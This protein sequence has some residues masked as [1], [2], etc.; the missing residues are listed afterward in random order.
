VDLGV[1]LRRLAQSFTVALLDRLDADDAA[2]QWR[3]WMKRNFLI[4]P[5]QYCRTDS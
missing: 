3:T 5:R 1:A 4:H 2:D